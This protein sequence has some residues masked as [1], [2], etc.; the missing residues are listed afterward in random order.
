VHRDWLLRCV[1]QQLSLP[2]EELPYV[3]G[4]EQVHMLKL[5]VGLAVS[6]SFI[7]MALSSQ[8]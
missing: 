8:R 4:R 6:A 3:D 7:I 2:R 1:M 5:Y